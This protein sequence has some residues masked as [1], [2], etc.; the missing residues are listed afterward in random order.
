MTAKKW[1]YVLI[2]ALI[3]VAAVLGSCAW[4]TYE[5][6]PYF[7]FHAPRE[8]TAYRL[9]KERYQN[10]GILR[11]FDYEL[12]ISGSSMASNFKPSEAEALTG[13]KAVKTAIQGGTL[14]EVNQTVETALRANPNLKV[15]V[16]PADGSQLD[17]DKDQMNY[18]L[19]E[20]LLDNNPF[21]DIFYLLNKDIFFGDTLPVIEATRAG[22]D[23]GSFDSY[24]SWLPNAQ[25]GPEFVLAQYTRPEAGEKSRPLDPERQQR[26]RE[27][28]IQNLQTVCRE[29]PQCQFYY[30][31]P[32]Y[33]ICYF[34]KL[35]RTGELESQLQLYEMAAELLL[36]EPNVH[37]FAFFEETDIIGD[38]NRYTDV[39]HYD[40]QVN[41]QI[42]KWMAQDCH[43][44]T[45]DNLADYFAEI[46]SIYQ[47]YDYESIFEKDV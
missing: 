38:L 31:F 40:P 2:A 24:G 10:N 15:V 9:Q 11:N 16:R 34:D 7:H 13:L 39:Y 47:S 36:Q 1:S 5:W 33:S 17:S 22:E 23:H 42:L 27:N 8:G 45:A 3:L 20:Y 44:L 41:T 32:P 14:R 6:D 28:I 46:S 18:S 19:P 43:R 25:F 35:Q 30:F 29:N 37:L 12:V 26:A 21:N 4:L